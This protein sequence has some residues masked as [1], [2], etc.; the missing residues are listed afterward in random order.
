VEDKWI[1]PDRPLS[2]EELEEADIFSN[3]SKASI[4]VNLPKRKTPEDSAQKTKSSDDILTGVLGSDKEQGKK[5]RY[6][7]DGKSHKHS[8]NSSNSLPNTPTGLTKM[9]EVDKG[10]KLSPDSK[11]KPSSGSTPPPSPLP[12]CFTSFLNF[13]SSFFSDNCSG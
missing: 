5:E 6:D 9:T 11:S 7:A 13:L 10:P 1:D 4:A 2:A 12:P 8:T 3:P